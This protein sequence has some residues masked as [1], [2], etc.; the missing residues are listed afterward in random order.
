MLGVP[1]LH[2]E[3]HALY[4]DMLGVPSLHHKHHVGCRLGNHS[5]AMYIVQHDVYG[6]G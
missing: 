5:I 6:V 1:S 4:I 3:H 2:H